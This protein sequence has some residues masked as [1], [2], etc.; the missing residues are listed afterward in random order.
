MPK[1]KEDKRRWKV[2]FKTK[3]QGTAEEFPEALRTPEFDPTPWNS[4][5]IRIGGEA[6]WLDVNFCY[7]TLCSNYGNADHKTS[8]KNSSLQGAPKR[9]FT[10]IYM[11]GMRTGTEN[12]QQRSG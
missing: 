2:K 11:Q 10:R 8:G 12:L 1:R 7:N 5:G 6:G 9:S 3:E 4:D